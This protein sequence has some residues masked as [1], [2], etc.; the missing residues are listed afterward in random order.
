MT[1]SVLYDGAVVHQRLAPRR[2]RLRYRLFQLLIELGEEP[3][4]DRRLKLFGFNRGAVFSLYERDHLAGDGRPL[5]TQVEAML[6]E[7]GIDIDGGPIRL[8]CMPRVL[9]YVFNPLSLYYCHRPD[10]TLAAV[11]LEVNNTFG[12]RHVYLVEAGATAGG[13]LARR[14]EKTF[15][16]SPFL[17]VEMTYDF[18]LAAPAERAAIAITARTPDGAPILAAAFA[19]RRRPLTDAELG[20]AFLSHPLLTLKVIAAIHW[21]ALKLVAKGVK[22]VRKPKAPEKA[23]TVVAAERPLRAPLPFMGRDRR[24]GQSGEIRRVNNASHAARHPHPDDAAHRQSLP[25]EGPRRGRDV[26]RRAGSP[27]R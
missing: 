20:R 2:H 16:V 24:N 4:L 6:A 25:T 11:A 22:P 17:P 10:E 12:E 26:R 21:E 7:A 18:R 3:A 9:G 1:A 13:Q 23:V 27:A 15:F 5:R 19:A 14:C 8:L